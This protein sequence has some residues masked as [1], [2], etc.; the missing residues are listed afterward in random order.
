MKNQRIKRSA[1]LLSAVCS[2]VENLFLSL[3][4]WLS[5]L[6]IFAMLSFAAAK[7][8]E[9]ASC[10][11]PYDAIYSLLDAQQSE[12]FDTRAVTRCVRTKEGT[13]NSRIE[14]AAMV[15]RSLDAR[16]IEIDYESLPQD[17]NYT[18]PSHGSA[19]YVL[20]SGVPWLR[21][22]KIGSQWLWSAETSEKIVQAYRSDVGWV[23]E[24]AER[25]P[26]IFHHTFFKVQIWQYLALLVIGFIARLIGRSIRGILS[27]ILSARFENKAHVL[28]LVERVAAPLAL[29]VAAVL[30]RVAAYSLG[31]ALEA[32]YLVY[33][34]TGV[35]MLIALVWAAQRGADWICDI[36]AL[37]AEKTSTKLDDQFVPLFRRLLKIFIW[38]CAIF[39]ALQS[40]SVDVG[41][42]V[43]GLGIGGLA[44]AL[45]AKDTIANFIG[46]VM[47]FLDC[48]FQIGDWIVVDST[49]GIV[50]EVGFRS[51]RIRTFYNSQVTVPNARFTDATIDN[52]GRREFR[53][54]Y[55][56]LDLVYGTSP[57]S[58]EA[59]VE[60][61]RAV[62]RANPATRKD[63][64]EVHFSGFG[65]H[66]LQV[67]VYFFVRVAN[68][69][70]ELEHR[71]HILMEIL[72]LAETMKIEFAFPTQ[73]MHLASAVKLGEKQ[74]RPETAERSMLKHDI[75][76][77]GPGGHR[78][79]VQAEEMVPGAYRAIK[80]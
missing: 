18:E 6:A 27:R 73:T 65:S 45:A 23:L 68:W 66:S 55:F 61:I 49:E 8:A 4:R 50:E 10:A 72:R 39:I 36:L 38:I 52:F 44:F 22:E 76:S 77:F 70:E 63:Y 54:S 26:S 7:P 56:T 15:K 67:M 57:D 41:A 21:V 2:G 62:I 17:A 48:P 71:H 51:T 75:E 53:R 35:V 14:V 13:L 80:D 31:L 33:R 34:G 24:Q 1:V 5:I 40:L 69:T 11:T 64:Y 47:I 9:A 32:A 30:W 58:M 29:G 59:F 16:G 46:S 74:P 42:L 37:R 28:A 20:D 3:G 12:Q 25:L 19:S 78:S 79:R 60:G 43:A